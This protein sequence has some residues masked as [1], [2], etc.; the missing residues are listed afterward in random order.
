MFSKLRRSCIV[1]TTSDFLYSNCFLDYQVSPPKAK[2]NFA[3]G[4]FMGDSMTEGE[5]KKGGH[6]EEH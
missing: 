1:I 4:G 6:H 5:L 3:P 2:M